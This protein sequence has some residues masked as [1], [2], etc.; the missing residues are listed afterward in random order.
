MRLTHSPTSAFT[1]SGPRRSPS[2]VDPTMSANSAVIGRISSPSC[3]GPARAVAGA[4]GAGGVVASGAGG[5]GGDSEERSPAAGCSTGVPHFGQN[6]LP[7]GMAEPHERQKISPESVPASLTTVFLRLL[8]WLRSPAW[9]RRCTALSPFR[10][11]AVDDSRKVTGVTSGAG[12]RH[13]GFVAA[14]TARE[15]HPGGPFDQRTGR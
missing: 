3:E 10:C 14:V 9:R 1:S 6:R 13:T 15:R 11:R 12:A 5:G 4:S 2:P 8:G 7:A